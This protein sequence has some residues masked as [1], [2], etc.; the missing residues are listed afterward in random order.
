LLAPRRLRSSLRT[1]VIG[2]TILAAFGCTPSPSPISSADAEAAA[3]ELVRGIEAEV[4][5]T[6]PALVAARATAD[7]GIEEGLRIVTIRVV[8]K[9]GLTISLASADD[10][11]LAAPPGLCVVGPFWNPL[12]AGLSDRCWGSPDLTEIS[13]LG[14]MLSADGS[15][16]LEA[17]ISRGGGRCDYAPGEWHLEVSVQPVVDGRAFGPVRIPN[18]PFTVA[19][20][21]DEPLALLPFEDTRVCS[22]PAAVVNRQGEPEVIE[23]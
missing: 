5:A 22:Y 17:T 12:D 15:S 1:L 19:L 13:G 21:D 6:E 16:T 4:E 3:L 10:V 9:M 20:G 14:P 23:P 7:F 8:E 11:V 2:L 18:V